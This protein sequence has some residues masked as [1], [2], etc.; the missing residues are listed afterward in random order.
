MPASF[1]CFAALQHCCRTAIAVLLNLGQFAL[2]AAHS[3]RTL[4]AEN[5]SLRKQLA[6]FQEHKVKPRRAN[7]AS[8]VELGRRPPEVSGNVSAYEPDS[9]NLH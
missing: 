9:S 4:S 8:L 7:D 6:L 2:L 1:L 5:L 3:R